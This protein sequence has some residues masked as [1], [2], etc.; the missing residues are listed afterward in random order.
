MANYRE[1]LGKLLSRGVDASQESALAKA[2]SRTETKVDTG[3]DAL[4]RA[5]SEAQKL[6]SDSQSESEARQKN[7]DFFEKRDKAWREKYDLVVKAQAQAEEYF[8]LNRSAMGGFKDAMVSRG[9]TVSGVFVENQ[10]EIF[11]KKTNT[12]RTLENEYATRRV[13]WDA[14]VAEFIR[15]I[16]S[17]ETKGDRN[18]TEAK[19]WATVYT[20][21]GVPQTARYWTEQLVERQNGDIKQIA[22]ALVKNPGIA[23]IAAELVEIVAQKTTLP[24]A[25][26]PTSVA[27]EAVTAK[28]DIGRM[29]IRQAD[30]LME[31]ILRETRQVGMATARWEKDQQNIGGRPAQAILEAGGTELA[32]ML[33][34]QR[35]RM[36]INFNVE[37]EPSGEAAGR[38][39][40]H[41]FIETFGLITVV[42]GQAVL[43]EKGYVME[44]VSLATLVDRYA[45]TAKQPQQ[46]SWAYIEHTLK[47]RHRKERA[48]L[49]GEALQRKLNDQ[50]GEIYRQELAWQK[51]EDGVLPFIEAYY[52]LKKGYLADFGSNPGK[53]IPSHLAKM[54]INDIV[55]A[56]TQDERAM[57]VLGMLFAADGRDVGLMS[58]EDR[59]LA[60]KHK[61]E[62]VNMRSRSFKEKGYTHRANLANMIRIAEEMTTH[63]GYDKG[64][65]KMMYTFYTILGGIQGIK[66]SREFWLDYGEVLTKD[67]NDAMMYWKLFKFKHGD[68]APKVIVDKR[69]RT[70]ESFIVEGKEERVKVEEQVLSDGTVRRIRKPTREYE[71]VKKEVKV[72]DI[73]VVDEVRRILFG[74]EVHNKDGIVRRVLTKKELAWVAKCTEWRDG[75]T[76]MGFGL[77]AKQLAFGGVSAMLNGLLNF[78]DPYGWWKYYLGDEMVLQNGMKKLK[79]IKDNMVLSRDYQEKKEAALKIIVTMVTGDPPSI[80]M[81]TATNILEWMDIKTNQGEVLELKE[82]AEIKKLVRQQAEMNERTRAAYR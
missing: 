70:D 37:V 34:A 62:V 69:Q 36:G 2:F 13:F 7:P 80:S 10:V 78:A 14:A 52:V 26:E 30:E 23:V 11:F 51:F 58:E 32:A 1:T 6:F 73:I 71:R 63:V 59:A 9:E 75:E 16:D 45:N 49:R 74:E 66:D 4:L 54:N 17:A 33:A 22:D 81:K 35:E 44:S 76:S 48:G 19:G 27:A 12:P 18:W 68:D 77:N 79:E 8:R 72:G 25:E 60:M 65:A 42:Y 43:G 29:N 61:D 41:E 21:D 24:R 20:K 3:T 47:I 53:G 28:E 50:E 67:P 82:A 15:E 56:W 40:S 38:A 46:L 55:A 31:E 64:V 39:F 57:R 5:D